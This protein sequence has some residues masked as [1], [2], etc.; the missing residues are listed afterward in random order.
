MG[1]KP[2]RKRDGPS[3]VIAKSNLD[4]QPVLSDEH[5]TL[6]S[7]QALVKVPYDVYK[8]A[9]DMAEHNLSTHG[10]LRLSAGTVLM[11][12]KSLIVATQLLERKMLDD[13][14]TIDQISRLGRTMASVA[15]SIGHL[16]KEFRGVTKPVP[17][18]DAPQKRSAFAL[19]KVVDVTPRKNQEKE[20]N[21]PAEP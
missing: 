8:E 11:T 9:A 15:N 20:S 10:F 3:E 13:E 5:P 2:K 6:L 4:E 1:T 16:T 18:K 21:D 19:G 17:H 14:T 12:Q 7:G